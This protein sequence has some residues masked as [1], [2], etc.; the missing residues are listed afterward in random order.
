MVNDLKPNFS[1][2]MPDDTQRVLVPYI[3]SSRTQALIELCITRY[4]DSFQ[5]S[6]DIIR[7]PQVKEETARGTFIARIESQTSP[8][9]LHL[10]TQRQKRSPPPSPSRPPPIPPISAPDEPR[11]SSMSKF[12]RSR[13]DS[14]KGIFRTLENYIV[15]CFEGIDCLNGSFLLVKPML[16]TRAKSEGSMIPTLQNSEQGQLSELNATLSPVDAKTL[17]LG[18]FAEN[19]MWWTGES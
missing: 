5:R 18:D 15:A 16:T 11:E 8:T 4:I 1:K 3:S 2:R 9:S 14:S 10:A 12:G 17:L 7:T 6:G 13:S 19:G